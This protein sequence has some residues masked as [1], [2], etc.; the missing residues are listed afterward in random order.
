MNNFEQII[1]EINQLREQYWAEVGAG[2]GKVW[3]L[4][5]KT[6]VFTIIAQGHKIKWV[7]S[8]TQIP[9]ET[10]GY[11]IQYEKKKAK[12][13]R[14]H[15]LVAKKFKELTVTVNSQKIPE[16][17]QAEKTATVTVT[18]PRGYLIEGLP[19]EVALEFLL[20]IGVR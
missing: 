16:Y 10:I 13:G 6:R 12:E 1:D 2:G 9:A 17:S 3:P 18:T 19:L 15:H 8:R 20:K 5:I 4:S 11:W 14:Q 7:A